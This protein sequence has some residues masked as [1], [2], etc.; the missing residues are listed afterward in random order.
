VRTLSPALRDFA[1]RSIGCVVCLAL[2]LPAGEAAGMPAEKHHL[3]TTGLHGNGKR[4]GEKFTVGL[5]IYHH[6]G[7]GAPTAER[8]PSYAREPRHF[9]A[10]WSDEWLLAEQ[11]RLLKAWMGSVV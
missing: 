5:C 1:L 9:R 8:G 4:R 3:L 2:G 10:R 6:R 7:I 11:E